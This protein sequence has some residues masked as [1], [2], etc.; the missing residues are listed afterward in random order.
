MDLDEVSYKDEPFIMAVQEKQIFYVKDPSNKEWSVVLHGKV[1][2]DENEDSTA[3]FET[4]S[5]L[6]QVPTLIGDKEID[7][8]RT[9]HNDHNEGVLYEGVRVNP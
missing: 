5:F 6:A 4:P 8:V 1:G 7:D 3:I 2:G 9:A